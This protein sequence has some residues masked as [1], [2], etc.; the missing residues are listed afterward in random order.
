M[1]LQHTVCRRWE[2]RQLVGRADW[3]RDKSAAAIGA[4]AARHAIFNTIRTEG[5]FERTYQ[6]VHRVRR[7]IYVT[8]F[9]VWLEQ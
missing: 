6:R 1:R 5:A 3:T 2:F 7:Q 9:A 8:T 4:D